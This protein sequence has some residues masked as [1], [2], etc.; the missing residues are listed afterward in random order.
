MNKTT[1]QEL[2]YDIER[3]KDWKELHKLIMAYANSYAN[4]KITPDIFNEIWWNDFVSSISYGEILNDDIKKSFFKG[5][6]VERDY[7]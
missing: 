4:E 7:F 6:V 5:F 3:T 1:L 2:L